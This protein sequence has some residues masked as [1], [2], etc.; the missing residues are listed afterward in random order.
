MDANRYLRRKDAL[1]LTKI[2]ENF[3]HVRDVRIQQRRP[4][5]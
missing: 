2:D 1:L 3:L 5:G 4:S